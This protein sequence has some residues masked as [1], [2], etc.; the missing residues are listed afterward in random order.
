MHFADTCSNSLLDVDVNRQPV[1][2][3]LVVVIHLGL[4]LDLAE[5]VGLVQS[6]QGRDIA[7]QQLLAVASVAQHPARGLNLQVRSQLGRVQKLPVAGNLHHHQLVQRPR[8]DLVNHPQR[9][10]V[11]F[12]LNLYLGVEVAASLQVVDQVPLSFVQQVIVD[13]VL[14]VDGDFLLQSSTAD[15][16]TT[17]SNQYH[18]PGI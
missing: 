18:R 2:R 10:S 3:T 4:N 16:V 14:F 15:A 9:L 13:S 7:F 11:G 8:V 6:L 12:F 5:T 1:F 17:R